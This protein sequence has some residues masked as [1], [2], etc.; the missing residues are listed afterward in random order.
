MTSREQDH[1]FLLH[2]SAECAILMYNHVA[3]A[4]RIWLYN[5]QTLR[6]VA[7]LVAR[8]LWERAQQL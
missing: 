6:D 5:D 3:I 1:V 7:Q 2:F 8:V 4:N